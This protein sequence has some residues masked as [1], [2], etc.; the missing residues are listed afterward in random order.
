MGP[1]SSKKGILGTELKKTIFKFGIS[2]SE[3]LFVGTFIL[4]Q[5]YFS[6]NRILGTKFRKITAAFKLNAFEHP[7]ALSSILK[8]AL[9][10]F[11]TKFLPQK[12]LGTK[13]GEIKS[14]VNLL[15]V[16][17]KQ[18]ARFWVIVGHSVNILGHCVS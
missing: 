9:S 5:P 11:G 2:T 1:S 3:Y 4:R 15:W 14:P 8:K 12:N 7:A 6:K 10:S 18:F 13:F 16:I 17:G